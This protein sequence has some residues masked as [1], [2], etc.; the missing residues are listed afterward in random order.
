LPLSV[1]I[2]APEA[3]AR[4]EALIVPLAASAASGSSLSRDKDNALAQISPY[5]GPRRWESYVLINT[6]FD[7]LWRHPASR[8]VVNKGQMITFKQYP[9]LKLE[10]RDKDG[11]AEFFSYNPLYGSDRT[12][13]FGAFFDLNHDGRPDWIVYYGGF[14]PTKGVNWLIW[15]QQAI[16]TDGDGRF[17]VRVYGAIDMDGDGFAEDGATTWLYDTNRDGLVDKAEHIV[18]GRITE[19]TPVNGR[20]ILGYVMETDPSEQPKIGDPMPV[21]FFEVIAGDI[22]SLVGG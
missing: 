19:I 16:D 8:K 13:E 7:R 18:N 6:L 22:K 4:P 15:N 9:L 5:D 2:H 1:V 12:Q 3:C 10:D 20:L 17:D 21:Q 14:L 11:T